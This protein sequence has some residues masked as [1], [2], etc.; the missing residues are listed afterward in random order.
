MS[1]DKFASLHV[2]TEYSSLDGMIRISDLAK[3]AKEY[4]Y[5]SL[6]I[7]D[8]GTLAGI[9]EAYEEAMKHDIK[10]VIG[11]EAYHVDDASSR[12]RSLDKR[13]H[14]VLLAKNEQ[15]F[16]NLL[17]LSY[18]AWKEFYIRPRMDWK[19]LEE[20]DTAGIMCSTACMAGRVPRILLDH[21]DFAKAKSEFQRY[22]SAFGDNMY[23]EIQSETFEEQN[24]MNE[25]MLMFANMV[26]VPAVAT[27]DSHYLGACDESAHKL[28]LAVQSKKP[29]D[30]PKV[31]SF[32]ADPIRSHSE[33]LDRF[34]DDTSVV[35]NAIN[36]A[37]ECQDA[38]EYLAPPTKWQLPS[39]DV[40]STSDFAEFQEWMTRKTLK[41]G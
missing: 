10:L 27:T 6:C 8:H 12:V 24:K 15:G 14:L 5:N 11:M 21:G 28:L 35:F 1:D 40:K 7:T 4:Q 13:T 3:R 22:Q 37:N 41:L 20:L 26:D 2:H 33:M 23:V 18:A 32:D 36:V 25:L 19:M 31:F 9:Y 30:D 16:K 34:K 38:R 17:K 29:I 39:F